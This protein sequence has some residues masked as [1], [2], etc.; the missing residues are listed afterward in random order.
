[1]TGINKTITGDTLV[2]S[3]S[4]LRKFEKSDQSLPSL[5]IPEPVFMCSVEPYSTRDQ[6]KLDMA[7]KCLIRE[8]PS[9]R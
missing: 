5:T 3:A 1:M 9:L 2:S 6:K 7:L 8:D 4:A